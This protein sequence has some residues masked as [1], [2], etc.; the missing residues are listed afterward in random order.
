MNRW[1]ITLAACALFLTP[2]FAGGTKDGGARVIEV[3][4]STSVTPL[5]EMLETEYTRTRPGIRVNISGTGSG[6][7]IKNAGV[8]YHIGMSSRGLT[9]VEQGQ[10]LR[11]D[12]IAIDGIAVIVNTAN[13][14]A[15]LTLDEI[16]GI[17]TGQITDWSQ[18]QGGALHGRIA[19]IS[20]EEGSGTRGAFE[21]LAGFQGRLVRG[22]TESTSTGAIKAGV[23]QNPLAIGYISLG[24]TDN[25]VKAIA[26]DGVAPSAANVI[27]GT[28]RIARPFILLT[29]G[30]ASA[31]ARAFIDWILGAE[32]QAVVRT[33]WIPAAA[34]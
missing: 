30:S 1:L 33:N 17:Y 3:G 2:V 21:E 16:R 9:A 22:A 19:V 14:A 25:S 32:G 6:D 5:M 12:I 24:S 34:Q 13:P 26:V 8:M 10:G 29:G 18:V 23:A 31:E 11:E 28:Y 4:G 15:R 7:G 27:N 20:R